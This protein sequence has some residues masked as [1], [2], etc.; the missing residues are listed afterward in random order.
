MDERYQGDFEVGQEKDECHLDRSKQA[1]F[2]A[3]DPLNNTKY[4]SIYTSITPWKGLVPSHNGV[5][6]VESR[7]CLR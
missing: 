6:A 2:G 7:Q 3:N 1:I 5:M 4:S